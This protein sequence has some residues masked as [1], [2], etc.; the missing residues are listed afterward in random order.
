MPPKFRP[1][2]PT[3]LAQI[4]TNFYDRDQ[5]RRFCGAVFGQ[6]TGGWSPTWIMPGANYIAIFD[7][8]LLDHPEVTRSLLMN[9]IMILR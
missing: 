8:E 2:M 4:Q 5:F 3:T 1:K 6:R 9:E 7:L